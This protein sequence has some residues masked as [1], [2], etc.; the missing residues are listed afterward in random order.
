MVTLFPYLVNTSRMETAWVQLGTC[1]K[2]A[3]SL[4]INRLRSEL[5]PE[6]TKEQIEKRFGTRWLNVQEREDARRTFYNL[7]S[8]VGFV[9][10]VLLVSYLGF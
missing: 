3:S 1:A 4:G 9:L 2:I 8:A 10:Y 5:P 6:A 7:V